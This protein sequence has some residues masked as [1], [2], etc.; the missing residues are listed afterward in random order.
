MKIRLVPLT[1]EYQKEIID[2]LNYYVENGFAA[3][4]EEKLPYEFFAKLLQ[5][6]TGYPAVVVQDENRDI[7]GFGMLRAHHPTPTFS[8]T[9][10]ITY[11]LKPEWTGKGIGKVMLDHLVQEGKKRG[12]TSILASI[13]SLNEGSINFH[14]K[15][16]F[17]ECGRFKNICKKKNRTFDVIYMQKMLSHTE[18]SDRRDPLKID[19]RE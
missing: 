7:L 10:E 3:Y 5:M 14:R 6:C 8:Q 2:I 1:E 15:N 13:S 17:R 4:P 19:N 12:L 11:F 9:A 16:G 18:T